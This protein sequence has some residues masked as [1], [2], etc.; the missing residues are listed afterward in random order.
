VIAYPALAVFCSAQVKLTTPLPTIASRF[1]CR[2]GASR[3]PTIPA[4]PYPLELR[5]GRVAP[6]APA[7]VCH[8]SMGVCPVRMVEQRPGFG[9]IN[10]A[11]TLRSGVGRLIVMDALLTLTIYLAP[12]LIIGMLA[13][14]WT[15]RKTVSL[16]E[17]RAE[18][19]P[20][21]KRSRF[22][23]GIWRHDDPP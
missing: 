20:G 15:A 8:L 22:L 12:F 9:S 14:R 3:M 10:G 23:L 18:S 13:K 7:K 11:R 4:E 17:V 19:D 5:L 2:A 1:G 21:R 6:H 16:S